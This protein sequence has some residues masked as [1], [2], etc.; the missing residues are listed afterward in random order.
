MHLLGARMN[1]PRLGSNA[2]WNPDA[3]TFMNWTMLLSSVPNSLFID[4]NDTVFVR[5]FAGSLFIW[6]KNATVPTRNFS[7]GTSSVSS[8]NTAGIFLTNSSELIFI[9]ECPSIQIDR[10][11]DSGSKLQ[12][13]LPSLA[14]CASISIDENGNLYCSEWEY[15]RISRVPLNSPNRTFSILAGTGCSGS[16][17]KTLNS[18]LG[19]FVSTSLDLFVA[20]CGNDRVQRFR[21]GQV[22][23]TTMAG[24]SASGT[25]SL[26]CPSSVIMDADGYL[27]IADRGNHRIVGSGPFGYRCIVGCLGNWNS[28]PS[29]LYSPMGISFDSMGNL[30]VIDSS[31]NRIQRFSLQS[32]ANGEYEV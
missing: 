8:S 23:A 1:Q 9:G 32:N 16:S 15:H 20:D 25:I 4:Q 22:N 11:T 27:F 14:R 13:S 21:N 17:T 3:T 31:N 19:I 12:W 30:Y 28:T 10:W 29:H 5:N 6:S 2:I 26:F 7:T 24:T 18:P